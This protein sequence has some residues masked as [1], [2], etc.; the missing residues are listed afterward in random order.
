MAICCMWA[1]PIILKDD[2]L[3]SSK[4]TGQ[5]P[6]GF[7]KLPLVQN[8]QLS[9]FQREHINF[10]PYPL[11]LATQATGAFLGT[12]YKKALH[13]QQPLCV[14]GGG[15]RGGFQC[16]TL[17][18]NTSFRD[19]RVSTSRTWCKSP[20]LRIWL[21][22]GLIYLFFGP[23][24]RC[25]RNAKHEDTRPH[26]M[27][28]SEAGLADLA[29]DPWLSERDKTH[30]SEGADMSHSIVLLELDGTHAENHIASLS[31]TLWLFFLCCCPF[32]LIQATWLHSRTQFNKLRS[33]KYF[34]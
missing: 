26:Y 1:C 22:G 30:L 12:L 25:N 6:K 11:E 17:N 9:M 32:P 15:M 31:P 20:W 29:K 10:H 33:W 19:L 16:Q 21:W 4:A 28:V 34:E 13:E 2:M 7:R 27:W 14:P 3:W 5:E 8:T 24:T 23:I 18:N